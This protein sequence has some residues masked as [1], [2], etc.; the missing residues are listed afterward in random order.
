[1]KRWQ[2]MPMVVLAGLFVTACSGGH[3]DGVAPPGPTPTPNP[4]PGPGPGPKPSPTTDELHSKLT[5]NLKPA[6]TDTELATFASDNAAFAAAVHGSIAHKMK[7]QNFVFSPYSIS[8]ALAMTYAGAKNGTAKEMAKALHFTLPEERLHVAFDSVDLA[9]ASH[10]K[11]PGATPLGVPVPPGEP[12]KLTVVNSLW[13]DSSAHI[14][15]PFLDTLAVNYGAGMHV[16]SFTKDTEAARLAINGWVSEQTDKLIPNLLAEGAVDR[17]TR[18]VLVNAI[19]LNAGWTHPFDDKQTADG[20]FT[21]QTGAKITTR[22]MHQ[23]EETLSYNEDADKIV[24][25]LPYIDGSL[26]MRFIV[27]A[28]GKFDAVEAALGDLLPASTKAPALEAVH[29]DI[30][31]PKFDIEGA[32]ASLKETLSGLGMESAFSSA[33]ADFTG[34]TADPLFVSDIAHQAVIKV[35]EK[36]T[37]AAAAT[38]VVAGT[39]GIP[40]GPSVDVKVDRPFLFAVYDRGTKTTLFQ[41]RVLKP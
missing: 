38:A 33:K 28:A 19:H 14:L 21:P 16:V 4:G 31:I 18:L 1:M 27:P 8:E 10:G 12:F 24:F 25:E 29:G 3:A 30:S 36:G 7:D 2:R 22:F 35:T 15:M 20:D 11:T 13:G 23:T 34:I 9:L 32:A 17:D 40:G 5:R 37:E 26:A 6:A 39:T 41:G